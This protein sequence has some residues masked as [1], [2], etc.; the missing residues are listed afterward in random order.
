VCLV[1]L[2][3]GLQNLP[4]CRT[5][6]RTRVRIIVDLFARPIRNEEDSNPGLPGG[7]YE[8]DY[9]RHRNRIAH[10]IVIVQFP[11]GEGALDGQLNIGAADNGLINVEDYRWREIFR[12]LLFWRRAPGFVVD[13]SW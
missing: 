10:P 12:M 5:L 2:D 9:A 1:S 6:L 7:G 8:R 3:A 11:V 13:K 4:D